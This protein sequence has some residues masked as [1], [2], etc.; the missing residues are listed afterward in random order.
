VRQLKSQAARK[1]FGQTERG[2]CMNPR[3]RKFLSYYRPHLKTF[4][5]VI[6]CAL[7]SSGAA[8][9]IPLVSRYI[10]KQ[11]LE[12]IPE[13]AL[14]QILLAGG[15]ML[16]L[17]LILT[18]CN[19]V[20]CCQGHVMGAKMETV[21][22]AELFAH[23]EKLSFRFYDE[24]KIGRMMSIISNDV[25]SMTE[26]YHHGPEDILRFLIKFVGAFAV[27]L[28]IN[29]PLTI[30]AFSLLPLMILYALYFNPKEPTARRDGHDIR[31]PCSLEYAA[32]C[33][34]HKADT[35]A[36]DRGHDLINNHLFKRLRFH[37]L[38]HRSALPHTA[39]AS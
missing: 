9:A 7:V 15:L 12:G 5:L 30:V 21:M 8:L 1:A 23:Y 18:V 14:S 35:H 10:T 11:V 34:D 19:M 29:V 38:L 27:L 13:N 16:M 17:I 24:Q 28:S 32:V 20:Y 22:R 31:Q 36:P 39:G 37:L 25:L 4:T 3:F 2:E 6:G 33:F 26:L